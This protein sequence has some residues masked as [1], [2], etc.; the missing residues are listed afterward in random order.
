MQSQAFETLGIEP[1]IDGRAIRAAFV[2][3]AR[4]YHPDRFAGQPPDVR[5]EAERRMKEAAAA[6]ELLRATNKGGLAA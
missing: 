6:Y 3:L 1:T 5:S 4:I 2:R